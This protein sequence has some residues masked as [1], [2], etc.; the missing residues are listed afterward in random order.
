MLAK[1]VTILLILVGLINFAPLLGI[2]SAARLQDLYG[3]AIAG[4]DLLILMRHRALLF[5][6]V[7]GV[8]LY[9]AFT[10]SIQPLAFIM[11]GVSMLGFIVLAQQADS[12]NP[13]IAKIINVDVL[14]LVLLLIAI[15]LF[16]INKTAVKI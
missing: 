13:F 12:Y 1:A 5:G 8:V 16:F 11:A 9:A 14:G 2:I 3:V 6:I 7:G 15:A 10:P 4:D